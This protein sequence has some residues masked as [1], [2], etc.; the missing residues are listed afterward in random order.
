MLGWKVTHMT[1][2]IQSY[3]FITE[4]A[5]KFIKTSREGLQGQALIQA[6]QTY[7]VATPN[8]WLRMVDYANSKGVHLTL[9]LGNRPTKLEILHHDN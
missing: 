6:V 8:Q 4:S 2:K 9:G 1:R 3:A 5:D 7:M